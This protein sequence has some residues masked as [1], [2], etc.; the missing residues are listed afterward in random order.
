M[1]SFQQ[2]RI[3]LIV[4]DNL[5]PKANN[6]TFNIEMSKI[7]VVL[8]SF[9]MIKEKEHHAKVCLAPPG[10]TRLPPR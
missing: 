8:Y 5:P 2:V 4:T 10:A 7:S 6:V 3:C 9:G 1:E